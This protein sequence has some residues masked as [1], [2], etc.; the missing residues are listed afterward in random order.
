MMQG[1][2]Y[3]STYDIA[4]FLNN[5]PLIEKVFIDLNEC[6]FEG[7]IYWELHQKQEL[8]SFGFLCCLKFV[9]VKDFQFQQHEH[10]LVKFPLQKAIDLET[11]ALVSTRNRLYLKSYSDNIERHQ[12]YFL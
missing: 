8:E 4:A 3:C 9:K 12:K 10:E 2:A 1:G 6:T 11:L 7:S 5:C